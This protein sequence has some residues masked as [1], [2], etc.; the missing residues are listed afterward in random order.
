MKNMEKNIRIFSNHGNLT[1]MVL[2]RNVFFRH[3]WLKYALIHST[4]TLAIRIADSTYP[5]DTGEKKKGT[6]ETPF[7]HYYICDPDT[8]FHQTGSSC[9]RSPIRLQKR[10]ACLSGLQD[11]NSQL[12][13]SE[14]TKS[15]T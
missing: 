7:L 13:N 8:I 11:N 9:D 3:V 4:H 5:P 14:K 12:Q 15:S 1:R 6:A 10:R 2:I